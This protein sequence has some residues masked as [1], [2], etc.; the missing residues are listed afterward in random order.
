MAFQKAERL[1]GL[2]EVDTG[3]HWSAICLKMVITERETKPD[4]M[5]TGKDPS[6]KTACSLALILSVQNVQIYCYYLKLMCKIV[7]AFIMYA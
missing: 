4:A 6:I 1:P 7:Y 5:Q 2:W 3:Q